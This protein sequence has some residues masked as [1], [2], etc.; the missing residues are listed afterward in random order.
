MTGHIFGPDLYDGTRNTHV[1]LNIAHVTSY[2]M[3]GL[4]YQENFLPFEQAKLGHE[5]HIITGNRFAPHPSYDTVYEPRMGPRFLDTGDKE[6]RGVIVHRLAVPFELQRHNNPWIAGSISLLDQLTP[7]IIHL[8]GVTPWSSLRVIFSPSAKL[9]RIVVDHHLCKFN[10]VPFTVAKRIFYRAFRSIC[11][12]HAQR[13]VKAW[14]PINED[15]KDV[16]DDVL[17]ISKIS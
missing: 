11:A 13:R 15:A 6:E 16:L 5:V 3:P 9:H 7:D 4:G 10:L 14:L 1:R 2:Y 17:G 8:H 12:K